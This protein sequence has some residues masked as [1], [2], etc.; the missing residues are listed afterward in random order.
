VD[1]FLHVS[2]I[3]FSD[4]FGKK[5]SHHAMYVLFKVLGNIGRKDKAALASRLSIDSETELPA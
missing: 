1:D 3:A 5:K 4:I 2:Y